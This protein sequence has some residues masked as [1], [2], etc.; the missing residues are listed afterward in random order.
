MDAYVIFD[1]A[2]VRYRFSAART[3]VTALAPTG[4]LLAVVELAPGTSDREAAFAAADAAL[5][6]G[7]VLRGDV[8]ARVALYDPYTA[9]VALDPVP[10]TRTFTDRAPVSFGPEGTLA[11]L[12]DRGLVIESRVLGPVTRSFAATSR[13]LLA[14]QERF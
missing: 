6:A 1:I 13:A 4:E 9:E 2:T 7:R 3:S 5:R 11:V 8:R 12:D 14:H 10:A